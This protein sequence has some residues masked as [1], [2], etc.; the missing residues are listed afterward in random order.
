MVKKDQMWSWSYERYLGLEMYSGANHLCGMYK[1]LSCFLR[2]RER[3][4]YLQVLHCSRQISV[5]NNECALYRRNNHLPRLLYYEFFLILC[6][7]RI[8]QGEKVSSGTL[9]R[10]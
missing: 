1:V 6:G 9:R 2:T 3:T 4:P 5:K 10:S 8:G 7:P